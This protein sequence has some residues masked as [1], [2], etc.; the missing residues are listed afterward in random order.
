MAM[1]LFVNFSCKNDD[2][3]EGSLTIHFKPVYEGQ[4]LTTLSSRPFENGQQLQ[5]G[6]ISMLISDIQLYENGTDEYL[7]DVELVDL[8][9][10]NAQD[11]EAGYILTLQG[12]P[13]SSYDGI[14]FGIGVPPD[15]NAKVP[16]DFPSSNPLSKT[17]YYWPS[18][19]SYIFMKTEGHL[20]TLGNGVFDLGFSIHTGTDALY[21]SLEAPIPLVIEDGKET[22][23]NVIIDYK[24]LLAGLDIK[25]MPQNHS[26]SDTILI[27]AM[28][29]NLTSNQVITLSH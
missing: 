3:A 13:A 19:D 25:S 15:V 22:E 24:K 9:F 17:G 4:P 12:I 8:S 21:R 6:L 28:M 16:A 2:P 10:D 5:I 29:N 7:D 11:A 23:L 14:K 18:W 27:Q 20:D 1:L 26:P